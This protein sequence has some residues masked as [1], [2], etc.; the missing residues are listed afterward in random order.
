[1][2]FWFFIFTSITLTDHKQKKQTKNNTD[3][4]QNVL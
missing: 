4:T 1:M 3:E 2:V